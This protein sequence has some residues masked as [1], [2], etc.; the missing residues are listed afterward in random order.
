MSDEIEA[1]RQLVLDLADEW[2][3]LYHPASTESNTRASAARFRLA[4]AVRNL[5]RALGDPS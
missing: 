3:R 2:E 4:V 1:K 5:R